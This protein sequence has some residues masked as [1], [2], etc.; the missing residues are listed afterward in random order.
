[1][2]EIDPS[3]ASAN[4]ID[5]ARQ[6]EKLGG[7]SKLHLDIEDGNFVPN[8]TFGLKTAAEIAA[9]APQELDAHLLALHPE[10]YIE[11]LLRLNV[12]RVA[13]HMEAVRYPAEQLHQI[14]ALGGEAGLALNCGTSVS[15]ALPYAKVLDYLLIMTSEPDGQGQRFNPY[16]VKKIREARELFPAS[17]SIMVDGGIGERELPLVAAAGADTV[18]MGRAVW[19]AQNPGAECARLA[20]IANGM[21]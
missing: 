6:I 1:M 8:I 18:V 14:R 2:I 17:V 4:Q 5:I 9:V 15:Q 11:A 21:G 12:R 20:N 16:M 19:G 10:C 3:I 13:V 7:A